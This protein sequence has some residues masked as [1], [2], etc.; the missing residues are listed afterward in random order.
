MKLWIFNI[1]VIIVAI[2]NGIFMPYALGGAI[3]I[4]IFTLIYNTIIIYNYEKGEKN[5]TK[6]SRR[7]RKG[8]VY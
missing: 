8:K 5:E 4:L 1:I 6:D 3:G 2:I 7:E